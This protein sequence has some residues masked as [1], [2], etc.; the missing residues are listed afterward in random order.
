MSTPDHSIDEKIVAAAK[1]EFH[2]KGF[3]EASLRDICGKAGVTTGALYKRYA[4]KEQL[5]QAVVAQTMDDLDKFAERQGDYDFTNTSDEELCS[6]CDLSGQEEWLLEWL[7]FLYERRDDIFLLLARSGNSQYANFQH[8][9]VERV[10]ETNY[11]LLEEVERRGLTEFPSSKREL[12]I[13]QSAYWQ[14]LYEPFIHEADW[15]EIKEHCRY[16]SRFFNWPKALGLKI[17]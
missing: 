4:G 11:P 9:W 8:D 2:A 5:F 3:K 16:M 6:M 13:L 7:R 10:M 14:A 12:H 15:E 17:R 1:V